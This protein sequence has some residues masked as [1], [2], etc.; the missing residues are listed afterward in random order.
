MG[1]GSDRVGQPTLRQEEKNIDHVGGVDDD[2]DDL[3]AFSAL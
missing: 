2:N 3:D 1:R